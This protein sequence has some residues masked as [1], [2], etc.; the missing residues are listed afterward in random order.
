MIWFALSIV[1][2]VLIFL[3]F[4]FFP[5][6]QVDTFRA[7]VVNYLVAFVL[8]LL[9]DKGNSMGYGKLDFWPFV[10]LI[11]FLFITL[12]GLM[13]R[14]T[15]EYGV[16]VVSV[17]V[18]M[19]LAIPVV[20]SLFYF[21]ERLSILNGMGILLAFPAL[22]L[23]VVNTSEATGSFQ[24]GLM[25]I[26]LFTGSGILDALL[27]YVQQV[28]LT[29][30]TSA[31]FS[32]LCFGS[33]FVFGAITLL[34]KRLLQGEPVMDVRSLIGGI[35]L[36][37]P[38]YGSIYFLVRALQLPGMDGSRAF[39]INNMGIVILSAVVSVLIFK[40]KFTNAKRLSILL[41]VAAI[42][43]MSGV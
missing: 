10:L 9:V 20:F 11:G 38:N 3:I 2:S 33:A 41:A 36:G 8:G 39:P 16:A 37:I 21:N 29:E 7:I 26:V 17:A 13:A 42:V 22:L 23:S 28:H 32:A 24:I 43:L 12:F 34:G 5:R 25:P 31:L 19:S 18:K 35:A 14:V 1:C 4:N 27:K 15:Q 30:Q 6:Y 40:E